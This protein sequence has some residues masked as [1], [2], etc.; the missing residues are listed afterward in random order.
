M[1]V[2]KLRA[3]G[4]GVSG[5]AGRICMAESWLRGES[6]VAHFGVEGLL[7]AYQ[8]PNRSTV[9]TEAESSISQELTAA[10]ERNGEHP[11]R[12]QI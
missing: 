11:L 2:E 7:L 4:P 10:S 9:P 12:R 1:N 6:A 8:L 5:A 3:T